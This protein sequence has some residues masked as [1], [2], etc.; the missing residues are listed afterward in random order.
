MSN[1]HFGYT[2]PFSDP[3][4]PA[5]P[6]EG[7]AGA[8][9]SGSGDD[10]PRDERIEA[11]ADGGR[12]GDSAG[13]SEQ[14]VSSS[15]GGSDSGVGSDEAPAAG[16]DTAAGEDIDGNPTGPGPAP[17]DVVTEPMTLDEALK[18]GVI[19][20]HEELARLLVEQGK[21]K[22]EVREVEDPEAR[23]DEKKAIEVYRCPKG[24]EQHGPCEIVAKSKLTDQLIARS[25]PTCVVCQTLWF[26]KMFPTKRVPYSGEVERAKANRT[27]R[28]LKD[29]AD[30]RRARKIMKKIRRRGAN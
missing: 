7:S 23:A 13:V 9:A 26:G 20:D 21:V 3:N 25:G 19:A 6:A 4:Q 18:S 29:D 1:E 24:H 5:A 15:T 30:K 14:G 12:E 28:S 17:S 11:N 10:H 2:W 16:E 22:A 8:A 27:K